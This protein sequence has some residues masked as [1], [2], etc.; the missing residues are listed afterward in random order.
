[1]IFAGG[2]SLFLFKRFLTINPKK[3]II[4]KFLSTLTNNKND[5]TR[6]VV[7]IPSSKLFEKS[8]LGGKKKIVGLCESQR[9][10]MW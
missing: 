4:V 6:K 5:P 7:L 8:S 9:R 2:L 1:L 10:K 3:N